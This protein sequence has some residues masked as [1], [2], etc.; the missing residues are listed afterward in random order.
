MLVLNGHESYISAE[1]DKYAKEH[2]IITLSLPP[3]SSHI[4]QPLDVGCFGPLKRAYGREIE[5]FIKAYITHITKVDFFLAFKAAYANAITSNNAKAGFRGAGLVPYDPE[6]VISKLNVKL[7]TPPPTT[8][9]LDNAQLWV[10]Q[11][12]H[13]PTDALLQSTLVRNRIANHQG[14]SPTPLFR[15]VDALANGIERIAHQLTLQTAELHELRTANQ[16]LSKR[17][18]AKKGVVRSGGALIVENAVDIIAQ[19]E[20]EEQI[21]RDM[22]PYS[23]DENE[24]L[25]ALR[26]C[27]KCNKTG[28]NARTCLEDRG[29]LN[30]LDSS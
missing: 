10:S 4:I 3:Y 23:R 11:T 15:T 6:S 5:K 20:V 22:L 27:S 28:H 9:P 1:F 18:R 14:S 8:N 7:R 2:N 30:I 29:A 21:R 24:G 26:R 17:R 25:P 19:K 16:L 13:N 12:P